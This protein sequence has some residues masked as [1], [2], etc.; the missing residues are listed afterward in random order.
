MPTKIHEVRVW[1]D[2]VLQNWLVGKRLDLSELQDAAD[3]IE[4]RVMEMIKHPNIVDVRAVA[5]VP[6]FPPPMR[7]VEILMPY[8]EKGSITDALE[9]GETFTPTQA[10]RIT[11][12]A[13]QGLTEMHERHHILHRDIK[14]PNLFLTGDADLIKIGDL[15]V[16]GAMDETGTAPCVQVAHPWAPPELMVGPG[17]TRS[18][19]LYSLGAVLL[20]LLA[21]KFDYASYTTTEVVDALQQGRP[22]LRASDRRLPVWVCRR[23]RQLVFKALHPDPAQRFATAREMSAALAAVKI[24]DWRES[25]PGVWQTPHLHKDE[26]WKVTATP[27]RTGGIELATFRRKS[28]SWRR[29]G[30]TETVPSVQH[31]SVLSYFEKVNKRAVS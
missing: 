5:T 12:A 27:A 20:E 23:L 19:D 16:A 10:L 7:V 9:A 15:G 2:S 29:A 31:A 22:P 1:W 6:G 25:E 30:E 21:G 14:S 26:H 17:V 24:A 4:P 3:L 28:A 11:Q 18:S 13:L 8:F